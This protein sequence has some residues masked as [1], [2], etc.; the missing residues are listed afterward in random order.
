MTEESQ[1]ITDRVPKSD[2][3]DNVTQETEI[4]QIQTKSDDFFINILATAIITILI[5]V[6]IFQKHYLMAWCLVATLALYFLGAS[7]FIRK[8]N[9]K[10]SWSNKSSHYAGG[11]VY[12]IIFFIVTFLI[13]FFVPKAKVLS[14]KSVDI[15]DTGSPIISTPEVEEKLQVPCPDLPVQ[16]QSLRDIPVIGENNAE[17]IT[18]IMD[19]IYLPR[20][21]DVTFSKDNTW[22]AIVTEKGFCFYGVDE[23]NPAIETFPRTATSASFSPDSSLLA[24]GFKDGTVGVWKTNSGDPQS[25]WLM[26]EAHQSP[27]VDVQFSPNGH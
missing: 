23:V 10:E 15:P 5:A 21:I 13:L 19:P 7:W 3:D 2:I 27:V 6:G 26:A 18:S 4:S 9:M 16:L 25:R 24:I 11:C 20:A 22:L 17:Y 12:T 1:D 8:F 14:L